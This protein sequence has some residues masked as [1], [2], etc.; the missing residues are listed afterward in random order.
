[1]TGSPEKGGTE[2]DRN[3]A[4]TQLPVVVPAY[5]GPLTTERVAR[6][7][8][9]NVT[10]TRTRPAGSPGALHPDAAPA[11]PLS[12]AAAAALLNSGPVEG[13]G[14]GGGVP[15]PGAAAAMAS[16]SDCD[17]DGP[18]GASGSAGLPVVS[19]SEGLPWPDGL[20]VAAT[21]AGLSPAPVAG[22]LSAVA[23]VASGF[24]AESLIVVSGLATAGLS[25]PAAVCPGRV[26]SADSVEFVVG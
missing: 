12:A 13:G 22:G 18:P 26:S 5:G 2:S 11:A 25:S 9:A 17:F 3:A 8:G 15:P 6:P 21:V 24:A 1:M 20:S 23:V 16:A 10:L 4:A 19:G 7:D 14:G